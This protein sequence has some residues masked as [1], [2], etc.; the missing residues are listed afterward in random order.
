MGLIKH[1]TE[2]RKSVPSLR[3]YVLHPNSVRSSDW[4]KLHRTPCWRN[5]QLVCRVL[6]FFIRNCCTSLFD[7]YRCWRETARLPVAKANLW[8][9]V[10]CCFFGTRRQRNHPQSFLFRS[11]TTTQPNKQPDDSACSRRFAQRGEEPHS[12][13][14][15]CACPHTRRPREGPGSSRNKR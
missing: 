12:P 8:L 3:F 11:T 15:F 1:C 14:Y 7:L 4:L 5:A 9:S 13:E 2:S 10:L 6:S